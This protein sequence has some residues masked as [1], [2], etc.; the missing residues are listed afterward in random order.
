[1]EGQDVKASNENVQKTTPEVKPEDE[2]PSTEQPK[3]QELSSNSPLEVDT[4]DDKKEEPVSSPTEMKSPPVQMMGQPPGYDPNRIPASVFSTKQAGNNAADWSATSNESLFSIHLGNNSFSRDYAILFGKYGESPKLEDL[5]GGSQMNP[6]MMS[7]ELPRL[8][9][10]NSSSSPLPNHRPV[11]QS[12]FGNLPPVMEDPLHEESSVQSSEL[13]KVKSPI[14]E[15]LSVS[16]EA[17]TVSVAKKP[18]LP[19]TNSSPVSNPTSLPSPTRFSDASGHS[20]SSFAFPVLGSH[21]S[22]KNDLVGVVPEKAEKSDPQPHSQNQAK[23]SK[24][25]PTGVFGRR[26]FSCFSCWPPRFC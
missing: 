15:N 18:P 7:G 16:S 25:T 26:W 22:G 9:E 12:E 14:K 8:D 5:N 19:E 10:W 6:F 4:D 3:N 17:L 20:G 2:T 13:P 23:V 11:S 1:M 21:D 24:E